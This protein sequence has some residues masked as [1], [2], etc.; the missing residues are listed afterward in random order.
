MPN[1]KKRKKLLGS[2][3]SSPLK[4]FRSMGRFE[5]ILVSVIIVVLAAFALSPVGN[6]LMQTAVDAIP[7][8]GQSDD[9]ATAEL[10]ALP[11]N[12]DQLLDLAAS[13][14]L[15]S[16]VTITYLTDEIRGT[17][18]DGR[19]F[20]LTYP[21][22]AE[23]A[24]RDGL[25]EYGISIQNAPAPN[26]SFIQK[27]PMYLTFG[28]IQPNADGTMGSTW[29]LIF[30]I[31]IGIGIYIILKRRNMLP[32]RNRKRKEVDQLKNSQAAKRGAYAQ[33]EENRKT[34]ADIAG[35]DSIINR[36]LPIIRFANNPEAF[37]AKGATPPRGVL[38]EGP[39][40][41]GKTLLARVI[42][43]EANVTFMQA[44]ASEWVDRWVGNGAHNIRELFKS[45]QMNA[46]CVLFIDEIDAIGK[47]SPGD[48][49]LAG[50]NDERD[51]AI[52]QFLVELDGF[53]DRDGIVIIGATNRPE[54]LDS[55]LL[56]PGRLHLR[57]QVPTPDKKA[58]REILDVHKRGK[59]FAD[60]VDF[61]AIVDETFHANGAELAEILNS[62]ALA[63]VMEERDEISQKDLVNAMH[64]VLTG[65]EQEGREYGPHKKELVSIHE[66]GHALVSYAIEEG[67]PFNIAT[68]IPR[69]GNGGHVKY[70]EDDDTVLTNE[71]FFAH[72]AAGAAGQRAEHVALGKISTGASGD[73]E[74]INKLAQGM[75]M[76][77][78]MDPEIGLRIVTDP[79]LLSDG[80]LA[81]MDRRINEYLR[82]G[83]EIA[84]AV[85]TEH[86]DALL[87]L[88]TA[89]SK[90]ETLNRKEIIEQLHDVEPQSIQVYIQQIADAD[91]A[92]A[93]ANELVEA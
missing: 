81:R 21:D 84:D 2:L 28:T 40:G 78:G 42:A 14:E 4:Q 13:G 46:P 17:L 65:V 23:A 55:A 90:S 68:I 56:R 15:Q 22:F 30:P 32:M 73:L 49:S 47:R 76:R 1:D 83:Q 11:Q 71:I 52:N 50:G 62:A 92:K 54:K 31:G 69:L 70:V 87:R 38:L 77:Y 51:Q 91:A 57:L 20:Y 61:D 58:R 88:A 39:T 89:L 8:P 18:A 79:S 9:T 24:I 85:L 80:E 67:L 37:T 16:P 34:F 60:D 53:A 74:G 19:E 59:H 27:I 5:Q 7:F 48:N 35:V 45:A 82:K 43:G 25:N 93:E 3:F 75:V 10:V 44:N 33:R 86:K 36:I 41:T 26:L 29:T 63:T 6:A 12:E 72:I 66:A 64:D